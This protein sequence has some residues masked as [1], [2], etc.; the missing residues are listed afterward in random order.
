MIVDENCDMRYLS[1]DKTY[2]NYWF[3]LDRL[4]YYTYRINE[5]RH[6]FVHWERQ[7]LRKQEKPF[8]A[9]SAGGAHEF[10]YPRKYMTN[11]NVL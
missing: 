5:E 10:I 3:T 8:V 4:K 2:P 11:R 6:N 1:K 7:T 9:L